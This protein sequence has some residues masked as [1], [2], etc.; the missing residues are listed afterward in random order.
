MHF[1]QRQLI[2]QLR[3]EVIS[4]VTSA[5]QRTFEQIEEKVFEKAEQA[6]SNQEQAAVFD[7]LREIRFRWPMVTEHFLEGVSEQINRFARNQPLPPIGGRPAATGGG[8]S[9]VDEHVL[10]E[11]I[12]IGN[13]VQSAN[14]QFHQSI[15]ALN[16]RLAILSQ[17][18]KLEECD[19]PFGPER[20]GEACRG[21]VRLLNLSEE[22]RQLVLKSFGTE[23]LERLGR[24]YDR[25]NDLLIE[26]DILPNLAFEVRR[27]HGASGSSQRPTTEEKIE[28]SDSLQERVPQPSGFDAH[29]TSP[30]ELFAQVQSMLAQPLPLVQEPMATGAVAHP[31][32]DPALA[33]STGG[34][35]MPAVQFM[36]FVPS[37]MAAVPG[38]GQSAAMA[39]APPLMSAPSLRSMGSM[40][41]DG[42][43]LV[44]DGASYTP[45]QLAQTVDQIQHHQYQSAAQVDHAQLLTVEAVK[46]QLL[47][48]VEKLNSIAGE[49]RQ[50]ATVD[51]DLIDLVGMLFEYMLNDENL[52]DSVKALLSHLHTPFLKVA[53]LDRQFFTR[54]S[55]PARRLLNAMAKAGGHWLIDDDQEHGVFAKMRSIV[56]RIL[57]EYTLEI[58]LFDE[59]LADFN[60]FIEKLEKRADL[61]EKRAMETL[62]G[63]EKLRTARNRAVQEVMSRTEG[64][65]LPEAVTRF[66]E[67]PWV[68]I[69]VFTLLRKG[70]ESAS[71][72]NTL[73]VVDDVIWS[74][75][76]KVSEEEKS[77]LRRQL[78]ELN[79]AIQQGFVLLGGY[80]GEAKQ[81][82]R[83]LAAAQSRA[84]EARAEQVA[85]QQPVAE[86]PPGQRNR[87][88][89]AEASSTGNLSPE[90]QQAIAELRKVPF[91]TW[92]EFTINAQGDKKRGKLSWFSPLT[93]RYMFVDQN[94]KQVGVRSLISLANSLLS[95][96]AKV[97]R[98]AEEPLIDRAMSTIHD[99]LSRRLRRR[100]GAV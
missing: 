3:S 19:N 34:V 1:S 5:V 90:L 54:S 55:H 83:E 66:L 59:V 94:G 38:G 2:D 68:D 48:Q 92:F 95:G 26:A 14:A 25:C 81:L 98:Q 87:V 41:P 97:I 11:E 88:R 69:L 15:H 30:S 28:P 56:D 96:D 32:M 29:P 36:P 80:Q 78:P 58:E 79:E 4:Q 40:R 45:H 100:A 71:W 22:I 89:A 16:Q 49:V 17:G 35:P 57:L 8:L 77:A 46:R 93:S 65:D 10:N 74:V 73:K 6:R 82:L 47:E 27:L 21:A 23:V 53:L 18:R 43:A 52:P 86:K 51:A 7:D 9:L 75:T 24:L 72:H 13:M 50:V 62:Q 39:G 37:A 99:L 31:A 70:T 85:V 84:L 61:A 33:Y 67:Q 44:G 12:I 60:Q 63:Q 20:L 76:P 42:V 91:G 64:H